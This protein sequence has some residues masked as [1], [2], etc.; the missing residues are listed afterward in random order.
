MQYLY[1]GGTDALHIRNTDIMEV[2]VGAL[3]E[4]PSSFV[5]NSRLTIKIHCRAKNK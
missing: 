2:S 4:K 5:V 1:F 3:S